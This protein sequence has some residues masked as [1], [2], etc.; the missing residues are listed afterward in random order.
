MS[1]TPCGDSWTNSSGEN[2]EWVNSQDES[3]SWSGTPNE[4]DSW[5]EVPCEIPPAGSYWLWGDGSRI[6]WGSGILMGLN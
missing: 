3:D 4:S 5:F 6:M 1:N 2:D